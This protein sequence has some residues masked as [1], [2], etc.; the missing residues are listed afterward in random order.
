MAAV[1]RGR[2]PTT[3]WQRAVALSRFALLTMAV[4]VPAHDLV[5]LTAYGWA[6][7]AQALAATGH[8]AYWTGIA[9]AA[10]LGIGVLATVAVHRSRYLRR[11]L[12]AL[13]DWTV[14]SMPSSAR[15]G[16]VVR[17]WITVLTAAIAVFLVQENVEHFTHHAG[18]L[19]GLAVL[20]A[21]EYV[22][23]IPLFAVL[24]LAAATIGSLTLARLEAMAEALATARAT[25]ASAPRRAWRPTVE[26]PRI[27]WSRFNRDLGR[28][29]PLLLDL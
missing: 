20:Y 2:R 9:V 17:L 4:L 13:G 12:D 14:A 16:R 29:P 11:R 23:A 6:G 15:A 26:H 10:A 22:W 21:G 8:G 5:Y 1:T 19:P 18:H 24:S 27:R 25:L 3:I 28:A 7:Q